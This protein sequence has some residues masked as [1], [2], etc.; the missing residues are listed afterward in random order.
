MSKNIKVDLIKY[1]PN[2]LD[3][4]YTAMRCCYYKGTPNDMFKNIDKY[5]KEDKL[6]LIKKVIKSGHLSTI[7]HLYFTFAI[8]GVDKN[9]THQLVRHRLASYSQQSLRY[10]NIIEEC[11]FE[12]LSL[13]INKQKSVED[14]ISLA[15]KYYTDVDETNYIHYLSSIREYIKAINNGVKKEKAR[16]LLCSNIRSNIVVSMDARSLLNFL[17]HRC[18][19]RAQQPIRILANKMIDCIKQTNEFEFLEELLGPK[20]IQNGFCNEGDMCCGRKP[21]LEEILDVY[22]RSKNDN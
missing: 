10:T 13:Y 5:T 16:N 12:E 19:T 2:P 20:C 4:A 17:A 14:G 18:C 1:T 8:S 6:K 7:E 11:S 15:S 21:T 22:N 9:C 3:V